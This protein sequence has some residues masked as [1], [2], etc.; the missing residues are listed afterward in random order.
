MASKT[1]LTKEEEKRVRAALQF[2]R[3][4]LGGWEPLSKVLG[5][6]QES[7]SHIANDRTVTASLAFRL[8]RLVK[9]PVDDLLAGRFPA[10]GTCPNCGHVADESALRPELRR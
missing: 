10:P 7:L 3:V 4:R 8:A 9:V 2:M 5:F 1:D 6:K